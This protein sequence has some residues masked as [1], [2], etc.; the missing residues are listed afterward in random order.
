V[1]CPKAAIGEYAGGVTRDEAEALVG[2]L[3]REHPDRDT[4]AWFIREEA[5]GECSLAKVARPRRGAE[6]LAEGVEAR[7]RP[8]HPDDPRPLDWQHSPPY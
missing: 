4:H 3:S 6:P 7:P 2:R 8:P 5:G 1:S